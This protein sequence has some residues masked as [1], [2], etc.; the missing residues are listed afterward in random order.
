MTY[1][2]GG[3]NYFFRS[4]DGILNTSGIDEDTSSSPAIIQKDF[5][6]QRRLVKV[7]ISGLTKAFAQKGRLGR[8]AGLAGRIDGVG[9]VRP[10]I[11]TTVEKAGE[12]CKPQLS[13]GIGQPRRNGVKVAGK[14]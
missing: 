1:G 14:G 2:A 3:Q 11:Q 12:S 8:G 5:L 10:A 13:K 4:S 6:H 9:I 7:K